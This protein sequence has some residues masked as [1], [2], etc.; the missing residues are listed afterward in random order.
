MLLFTP[1][2]T[3]L[4]LL[5]SEVI[6]NLKISAAIKNITIECNFPDKVA[7]WV[8]VNML[9]AILRNLINNAIK[10]TN[11][12]GLIKIHAT[13]DE[14]D[15]IISVSDNGIGM[16]QEIIDSLQFPGKVT[17][18]EG[19]AHEKGSGLGMI[20]CSEFIQKHNGSMIVE[21]KPNMGSTFTIK[22][23]HSKE[24]KNL[25]PQDLIMRP[26]RPNF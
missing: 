21:S 14:C 15:I 2:Y 3:N 26:G 19:T 1:E 18:L 20:I 23:P 8:D 6:R 13:S 4:N 9:K 12:N 11:K 24:D 16:T 17:S 22:I 5:I 10:F 7:G 25:I